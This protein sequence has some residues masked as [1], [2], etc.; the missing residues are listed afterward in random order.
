MGTERKFKFV[1][2]IP[3]LDTEDPASELRLF[4]RDSPDIG[5]FNLVDD[6]TIKLSGSDIYYYKFLTTEQDYDQ[7][8]AELRNKVISREAILTYGHY[9]PS[10]I[11][12]SLDKF[13]VVQDNNQIFTF[14]QE[15]IR[16]A[17][18]REP[19]EGDVLQP[20]FQDVKF[21]VIEVQEDGFEIYGVYHYI[22]SAQ[23]YRGS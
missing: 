10:V 11:E 6:E 2:D 5:L 22:L 23:I 7:D 8:Y 9:E 12:E 20:A 4:D 3:W 1:A 13:G 16:R 18:G 15:Y 19:I 14:N 21:R 17:L